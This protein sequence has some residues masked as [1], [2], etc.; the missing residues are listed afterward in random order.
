MESPKL[1][2]EDAAAVSLALRHYMSFLSKEIEATGWPE[3]WEYSLWCDVCTGLCPE[4]DVLWRLAHLCD[5][6]WVKRQVEDGEAP[7]DD[8]HGRDL[9]FVPLDEWGAY[10][11]NSTNL[12][13]MQ[14]K[15]A[16]FW[17]NPGGGNP[18]EDSGT[19]PDEG[20]GSE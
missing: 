12:R 5:G 4:A 15:A 17:N 1:S 20:K 11:H 10:F 16:L 8:P 7:G 3:D 13:I 18:A 14:I 9:R 19:V 2:P 6:W